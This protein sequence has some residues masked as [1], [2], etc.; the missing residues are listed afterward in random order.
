MGTFS[1]GSAGREI[2]VADFIYYF[3]VLSDQ[4]TQIKVL[5]TRLEVLF[6]VQPHQQPRF[7]G[8]HGRQQLY[9]LLHLPPTFPSTILSSTT[10]S[11]I[12]CLELILT[13]GVPFN[14]V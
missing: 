6:G 10:S 7:R 5:R 1:F 4:E 2:G 3:L 12:D 9:S 8:D 11:L 14:L 13:P